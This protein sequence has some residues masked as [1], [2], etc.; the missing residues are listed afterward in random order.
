MAYPGRIVV[1][2]FREQWSYSLQL[3]ALTFAFSIFVGV[4]LGIASAIKPNSLLD[5]FGAG[6]S[7]FCLVM[8]S[9]VFAILRQFVFSAWLGWLPT[10]YPPAQKRFETAKSDSRRA[11]V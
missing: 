1:G 4:G 7:I 3:G 5:Y 10:A 11:D 9:F 2:I 6:V 8:P